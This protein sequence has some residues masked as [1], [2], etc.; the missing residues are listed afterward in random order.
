MLTE[1]EKI[2]D[3]AGFGLLQRNGRRGHSGFKTQPKK[4]DV[5]L[6]VIPRQRQGIHWRVDDPHVRTARFRLQ[7]RAIFPRHAHRIAKGTENDVRLAGNF[8]TAVD[9]AHWQHADR[10]AGAV[11]KLDVIWQ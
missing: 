6:R 2:S 4:D 3:V 9:A 11:D 10:A 8:N 7:Q 5:A 1:K